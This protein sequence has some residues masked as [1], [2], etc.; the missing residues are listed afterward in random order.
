MECNLRPPSFYE[1]I[2][3]KQRVVLSGEANGFSGVVT[4]V[5]KS[6][7]RKFDYA[8][9]TELIVAVPHS[10]LILIESLAAAYN[11]HIVA[12]LSPAMDTKIFDLLSKGGIIIYN[13]EI[14]SVAKAAEAERA[15]IQIIGITSAE[16]DRE[17]KSA[18]N[19]FS[20]EEKIAIGAAREL[21]KKLGITPA[22][23]EE[24]L[25]AYYNL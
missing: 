6:Q 1:L 16:A 15:D 23:F 3:D 12:A 5:L 21:S 7:N 8:K 18:A 9:D 2:T 14:A 25:S 4:H 19:R 10:P 11:P 13:K 24:G 20:K 17:M 22:Q